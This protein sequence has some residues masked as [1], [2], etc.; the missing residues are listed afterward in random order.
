MMKVLKKFGAAL[1]VLAVGAMGVGVLA[2]T[3]QNQTIQVTQPAQ[4]YVGWARDRGDL[5]HDQDYRLGQ[6]PNGMKY[7]VLPNQTPPGQVAMRLLIDAG[8][9]Q[10]RVGEEGVAHFLEHLA[11][12]GTTLY[13]DG[14]VQAVLEGI[15][16]QMAADVNAST[17]PDT[18]TF[19][20]DLPRNDPN[21]IDTGLKVMRQLVSDMLIEPDK[22]DAERGV[23]LAEER[24]RA[25]PAL[26]AS[27]AFLELQ[28]GSHPYARSPIGLRNVI[29]TVTPK[30]IRGFY[31][32]FYRPERATLV[33]VGDVRPE[34][35]IPNLTLHFADWRGRGAPGK[36]PAPIT[37]KP[38]SPDVSMIVTAG[39]PD[40]SLMLRWFE[41][42]V[43]RPHTKAE[44]RERLVEQL[45][46]GAISRRMQGLNEVA[47]KPAARIGS[48]AAA[49]IPEV[50]SGQIATTSGVTDVYKALDVMVKAHRQAVEFGLTQEELDTQRTLV[51]DATKREADRG[52]TGTSVAQVEVAA[53]MVS[54][55]VPFV[56][57]QQAYAILLEQAPTVTLQ[58]VNAGLKAR[59][60]ETP[61]LLYR[62][63]APPA[64][65]EAA[66]RTAFQAALAAPVAAYVP[67][68]VKPWPYTSF[69]TP[70]VV[71]NREFIAD[72]GV[73]LVEF[74]NG[75]KLTV[76]PLPSNKDL[77]NI[78]VRVGLGRLQMPIN[79]IDASDMGLSLWSSGGLKKITVTEQARTLAGKRVGVAG[80]T[81]DDAYSLDNFNIT[82]REDLGTQLEL[83]AAMLT[84]AAYRADDWATWMAQANASDISLNMTPSGVLEREL[85][86]LLH[87]EDLRWT[88]NTKE[89]RETWKPEDS[90]KYIKPIVE[91]SPIEIIV[92]G[93][94]RADLVITE[95]ARTLGAL[96]RRPD[97]KEPPNW[98]D[99]DFP[100]PGSTSLP[101]QGRADQGYAL[102]GWPTYQGAYKSIR[103]ERIGFV[104]GQMLRDNATRKFRSEGGATYSPMELVDFPTFLPDFGYIAVAVEAPPNLIDDI[105]SEI[106]S[107]AVMLANEPQPQ[108]EI[109]RVTQPKIEQGRRNFAANVG[110]WTELLANVHDDPSGLEY[111]RSEVSDYRSI[112]PADVQA[113]AKKWLKPE[114]AWR[115]RIVP[116][117]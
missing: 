92:V 50:W 72:L 34:T 106:Q 71:A 68:A 7:L 80:R 54:S 98:R 60:R 40:T 97:F 24:S 1:A 79:V 107:I 95:V 44:R 82:P 91:N 26:E 63:S 37:V 115:L 73:T 81:L 109:T 105:Q 87:G 110:Y 117:E 116:A 42:Y 8:S 88:I 55:D 66:L 103:E 30:T 47:G 17:G 93:D 41:P 59:F 31:D 75:V 16:L 61:S 102:I 10:E 76:K 90:V 113:M 13:P 18:T 6:L 67:D 70:G 57:L 52:R 43:E 20:L 104:L 85:D 29:E 9:M 15:G 36:D 94:V 101:H 56:S 25:G 53:D 48:A 65:G 86:R 38:P 84:D 78:R 35:V 77:I 3:A 100:E 14:Q 23:V 74:E 28:L 2:A 5:P 99:V 108:S 32:A 114:T 69:G 112:T 4:T 21:S 46:A 39:A 58:E 89:M 62:G 96:P 49:R 51:L 111:I 22:V 19:I 33:I 27:K 83:T 64:G 11:F 12:R 45:T